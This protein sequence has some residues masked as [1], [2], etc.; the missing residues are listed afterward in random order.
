MQDTRTIFFLG[1]PGC[2][3]GTQAKSLA[4]KTGWSIVSSGDQFRKIATEDSP[5]G[6]KVRAE[7]DAGLLAPHWFAM[8]LYQKALFSI[9]E[10]ASA[11]FDGF[12]RK[13]EEAQLVV[14][15]LAWLGR[16][17]TVIN[18]IISDEM[19]HERIK[20]RSES[21]SRADDNS[22]HTRIEEYDMYTK[23]AIDLFRA[24]GELI[25]IDGAQTKENITKDIMEAL[26]IS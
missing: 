4:E 7:I 24:A 18:L 8:Y 26:N 21:Q 2:G 13:P 9:P 25:D 17:F 23:P 1:K 3:K 11:I 5:V 19:V 20:V 15:S 14:E 6:R 10:G 22:V 16:S 12:N